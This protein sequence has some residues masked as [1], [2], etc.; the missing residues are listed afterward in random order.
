[1][2]KPSGDDRGWPG[3]SLLNVSGTSEEEEEEEESR[4]NKALQK[5][6]YKTHGRFCFH[7]A[8]LHALLPIRTF[9]SAFST[10]SLITG[11]IRRAN[12]P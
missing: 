1:M 7:Q 6:T 4:K 10:F 2:R 8:Q 12:R 11:A 3:E 9:F 5:K